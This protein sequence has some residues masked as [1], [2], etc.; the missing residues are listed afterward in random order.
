MAPPSSFFFAP[1]F[2]LK[3]QITSCTCREGSDFRSC[4]AENLL[5]TPLAVGHNVQQSARSVL[6]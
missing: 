3:P 1:R 2:S 6:T 5:V 4:T